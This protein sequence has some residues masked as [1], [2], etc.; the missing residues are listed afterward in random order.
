MGQQDILSLFPNVKYPIFCGPMANVSG[1]AL[2]VAVSQA[3]GYGLVGGGY[4]T[5]K[6]R[7]DLHTAVESLADEPHITIGFGVLTFSIP[8]RSVIHDIY[9]SVRGSGKVSAI[10]LFGGKE[11]EWVSDLK[12]AFP[13]LIVM[14]QVHT[15][16]D[17]EIMVDAGADVIIAQGSDAGGHGGAESASIVSLVPEIK[18]ACPHVPVL[19]A[20]GIVSGSAMYAALALGAAG[21]VVGTRL[22]LSEESLLPR[23]AKDFAC[24]V[25]DGG[26]TTVQT[27]VYDEMRGTTDW[28]MTFTGRAIRNTTMEET[29]SGRD[30]EDIQKDYK[31]AVSTEDYSRVVCWGGTG[32]GLV[33]HIQPAKDIV[34]SFIDEYNNAVKN[35]P[36]RL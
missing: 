27:R 2:A 19:A 12:A 29:L 13:E 3:G 14:V 30:R 34:N 7:T 9:A 6:L 31:A 28:P 4:S 16:K 1:H 8:D 35:A 25:A 15:V 10:W 18:A 11:D 26:R 20:G 23:K 17:A 24:T 5:D 36:G 22:M 33:N 32:I 21:V